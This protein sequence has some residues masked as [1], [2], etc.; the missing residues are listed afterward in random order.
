M[1]VSD[2]AATPVMARNMGAPG[3]AYRGTRTTHLFSIV[4]TFIGQ[5]LHCAAV[6]STTVVHAAVPRSLVVSF[7][8][9]AT[10][11]PTARRNAV[12]NAAAARGFDCAAACAVIIAFGGGRFVRRGDCS[13]RFARSDAGGTAILD[14]R[15]WAPSIYRAAATGRASSSA[16]L[17]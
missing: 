16:W 10:G 4:I 1:H 11:R 9:P 2:C 14:I 15:R 6:V 13:S 17:Q 3:V 8:A 12:S 7:S 5:W